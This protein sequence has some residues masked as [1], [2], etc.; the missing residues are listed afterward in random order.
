MSDIG[1][2]FGGDLQLSSTGDLLV[3]TGQV[4]SQQRVLRRLMTNQ[5]DYIWEPDYGGNIPSDIGSTFSAN[6]IQRTVQE[7][8]QLEPMV[9]QNPVPQISVTKQPGQAVYLSINYAT[10]DQ[11]VVLNFTVT[12]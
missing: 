2:Y 10:Q 3:V 7:Q 9:S 12:P 8:L 1:H 4:E 5:N 11:P 6:Q